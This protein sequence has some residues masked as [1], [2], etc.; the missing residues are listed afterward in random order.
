M[1]LTGDIEQID[2]PYLDGSSNGLSYLVERMK[3]QAIS[4]HV[5]L[6]K[7]ERS[8]LASLAARLL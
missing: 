8:G 6:V 7:S 1:I 4:G 3:G 5:T 2:N